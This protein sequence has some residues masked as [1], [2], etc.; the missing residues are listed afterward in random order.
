[1]RIIIPTYGRSQQQV[2]YGGLPAHWKANT[3]F[4]VNQ[5]DGDKL[6]GYGIAR[7]GSGVFVVPDTVQTIAQKR[8]YIMS[9]TKH[10]KILMLDDDLRFFSRREGQGTK[11]FQ[12][13]DKEVDE[14]FNS[15]SDLLDSY[16]H[17][18]ISARQGNNNLEGP[19]EANTR[20]V[21]ALG[22]HIPTI[23]KNCELGRIE[24]REDMDYTLQLLRKGLENRV[25]AH[26]CVDQKYN[27]PGGASLERTMEASNADAKRLA[28][29]HPGLVRVAEKA[30]KA[31]IPRLEV[32]CS[33]KKALEQGRAS[34]S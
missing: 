17:V 11:L 23:L 21:Y 6:V 7:E 2:T 32:V 34:G 24:H 14:A 10:E 33:W 30:Y 19:L 13:T 3:D 5:K 20:M 16:P 22:Y 25:L 15:I 9:T 8:A 29:L 27:A 28:E 12:S 1:M 18:G 31:S 26:F 4:Y